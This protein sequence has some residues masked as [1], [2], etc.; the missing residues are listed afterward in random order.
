MNHGG[1]RPGAGRKPTGRPIKKQRKIVATDEEWE[2]IKEA[3][4]TQ[5]KSI[6]QYLLDLHKEARGNR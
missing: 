3:A 6:S 1:A 2:D 5:G 4:N